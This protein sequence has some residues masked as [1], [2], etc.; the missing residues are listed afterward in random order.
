[1]KLQDKRLSFEVV[2]GAT[3]EEDVRTLRELALVAGLLV[4]RKSVV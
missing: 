1:M 4:D 3:L 2:P